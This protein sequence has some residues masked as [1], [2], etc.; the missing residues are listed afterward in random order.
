MPTFHLNSPMPVPASALARYHEQ[1][2]AFERLGPPWDPATVIERTGDCYE[3]RVVFEVK[4][5]GFATRWEAVHEGGERGVSFV[6]RQVKGPFTSWKHTHRF[7]PVDATTSALDDTIE[8][9]APLGALGAA[10][11]NV[12]SRLDRVFRFRHRRTAEDVRRHA[13]HDATGAGPL[14]ILLS[15]ASGLLGQQLAAFLGTGG[16]TIV[17]LVRRPARNANEAT[18]D[19]AKGVIDL[20]PAGRIDA[21]VHLSGEP[22]S[23]R[24][25][26]ES[27]AEMIRS[28]EQ[29]TTLIAGAIAA[30]PVKPAVFI[31]ASAVGIYGN[32]GDERLTE[33]SAPGTGR[34]LPEVCTRWERSTQAAKDAGIRTVNLRIGVVLAAGGGALAQLLPPVMAGVGGPVG[35]GRQGF[36]WIGVDDLVYMVHWL[37]TAPVHGPVNAVSP[38]GVSNREMMTTLGAVVHRPT[39][40]PL[41]PFAVR[42][43]FGEMG[44]ELLLEGQYVSPAA[45]VAA[46]FRFSFPALDD[47]LRHQLGYPGTS[48]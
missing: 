38:N 25:T 27:K 40:I 10:V 13:E 36:P 17:Q 46:G 18:W 31:S 2:T 22:V 37:L 12:E 15:G 34:F 41:P 24:W 39:V 6:D 19:P 20:A 8:W 44:Q 35:N 32:R 43:M 5:A 28:R 11:G 45:A 23:Q 3:G 30:M 26:P 7:V 14:R 47:L 21:V 48:P 1:P 42:A 4:A 16:H 33:Q 29:S 9:V